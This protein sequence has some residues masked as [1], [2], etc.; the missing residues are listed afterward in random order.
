MKIDKPPK[1]STTGIIMKKLTMKH[2]RRNC[3]LLFA[4]SAAFCLKLGSASAQIYYSPGMGEDSNKD[5]GFYI[6]GDV[7]PSF[8]QDFQSSRF[9]FPGSFSARPGIRLDAEPG[10]N[11]LATD[12]LTLGAEFEAGL[13]YNYLRSVRQGGNPT[14]LRGD[15][16][17]VPL[18]GNLVLKFHPNSFVAPYIGVGGGGDYSSANIHSPG[19]FGFKNWNDEID[20]AVQGKAGVRFRLNSMS[21][22][23]VG[24]KFL[25]AF[26]SEGRY[27]GT[28]A[29]EFT[30]TVRF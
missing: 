6:G 2:T 15:Y 19:F 30:F 17:Q 10:Y 7:G 22:M 21:D 26:P 12:K 13:I 24:Y 4:V 20:P 3:L 23:G 25:A 29:A 14:S 18:L 5:L 27:I 11:F 16:Y 28:H 1:K 9:G 8:V